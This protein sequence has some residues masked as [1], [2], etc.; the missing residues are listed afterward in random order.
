MDNSLPTNSNNEKIWD[1]IIIGSGPAGLTAAVYTSRGAAS[2]LILGGTSWGG[3]LM[4]T[5]TVENYPGFPEGIEGPDLMAKMRSQAERFGATF[6][7][8]D[9]TKIDLSKKPFEVTSGVKS[10]FAKTVIVATG[11]QTVWLEAPGVKEFIGRGVSSC[12]PCDASFFKDKKVAVVGGGDSAMEEAL[13]LTKYASEVMIIHRRE[14]FRASKIMQEKV[15]KNPK[16]K[17]LWNTEVE[18]V[19]GAQKVEAVEV[20]NNKTQKKEKIA[21]D[22][23]FI[24]IGHKPLSEIFK[25]QLDTDEKGFIKII[26]PHAKTSVPGVFVA[27]D[28]M[29]PYYKQAATAVG[30]GCAAALE[31]LSYLED[32]P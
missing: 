12:A 9:A 11:A 32:T 7:A 19:E 13:V 29:D 26:S 1:V 15:T 24:A 28:V 5:T 21:L 8:E 31:A 3:Q 6:L 16:I 23:V 2:T 30:S 18:K 10:Y 17:I 20:V 25:G 14:E 22:G 27:G 4:F